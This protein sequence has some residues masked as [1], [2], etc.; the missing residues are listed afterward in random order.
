MLLF[1][2][3]TR[4]ELFPSLGGHLPAKQ[5]AA[6]ILCREIVTPFQFKGAE[7]VALF[8]LAQMFT[9]QPTFNLNVIGLTI[10]SGPA[11]KFL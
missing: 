7:V 9:S 10:L 1:C 5:L 11:I 6:D 2:T 8:F 3:N 4:L